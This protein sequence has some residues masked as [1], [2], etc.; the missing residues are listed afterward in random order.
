MFQTFVKSLKSFTNF[1]SKISFA[2]GKK[3]KNLFSR[4]KDDS[5]YEELEKLLFEAD[6]G[7]DLTMQLVDKVR[8]YV[9]KHPDASSEQMITLLKNEV[10]TLLTPSEE[11]QPTT[12]PHVILVVGTNGS[13]KTTSIAKLARLYK[14][15]GKKVLVAA[16]DT[17]R[18][19][20]TDQLD[21][22][23]NRIGVDIIKGQ[24][25][26]DPS[27]VAYDA[28]DAALSRKSDLLIIDTAGRLHTKTDLMQELEKIKRVCH[29]KIPEAPH[30]TLL[31][32][33]ATTGQNAMDQARIFHSFTPLTGIVLTKLD[34]TAKGGIVVAIKKETNLDIKWVGFGEKEN[35]LS[36]FDK[37]A[38]INALFSQ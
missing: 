32:L 37:K 19:A 23:A 22:W 33:D 17:F 4:E 34:G 31:V 21:A 12:T 2:L 38:F 9:K 26:G 6:F 36:P 30:E 7:G 15:E 16:C 8:A 10:D 13:G 11:K 29:K 28:I 18:A 5:F 35:D 3:L 1:F 14:K 20:A 25:K 24:A 27:A